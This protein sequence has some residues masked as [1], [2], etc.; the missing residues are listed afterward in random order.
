MNEQTLTSN[1][2]RL[3]VKAEV[4]RSWLPD[5]NIIKHRYTK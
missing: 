1:I 2:G 3:S 5:R 4:R